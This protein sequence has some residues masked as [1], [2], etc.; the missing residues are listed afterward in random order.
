MA[1]VDTASSRGTKG[2][3]AGMAV[4]VFCC[5]RWLLRAA[6]LS[7][8]LAAAS[9]RAADPASV[10]IV[11]DGSGSMWGNIEGN[12]SSK[13]VLAREAVRRGLGKISTQTRVGVASFGHRRG[14]CADVE[15]MRPPRA[16]RCAAHPRAAGKAQP[17]GQRAADAG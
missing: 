12:R 14:D 13:L 5:R 3:G 6:A 15:L 8:A 17:K 2:W 11:F 16:A 9:V 7:L 1:I 4:R 10:V